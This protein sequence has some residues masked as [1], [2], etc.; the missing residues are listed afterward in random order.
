MRYGYFTGS[1]L[2]AIVNQFGFRDDYGAL[3][4]GETVENEDWEKSGDYIFREPLIPE[5]PRDWL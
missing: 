2:D 4:N 1:G 3:Y 5:N